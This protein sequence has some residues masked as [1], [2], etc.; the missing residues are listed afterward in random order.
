[1]NNYRLHASLRLQRSRVWALRYGISRE[2]RPTA[3]RNNQS[4]NYTMVEAW[5]K[6]GKIRKKYYRYLKHRR[7]YLCDKRE[8]K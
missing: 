7:T 8:R 2:E 5:E 1:M 4:P 3:Q 6:S